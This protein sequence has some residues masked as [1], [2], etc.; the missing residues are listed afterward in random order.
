MPEEYYITS[1]YSKSDIIYIITLILLVGFMIAYPPINL[2]TSNT[3]DAICKEKYLGNESARSVISF[4]FIRKSDNKELTYHM[5]ESK[6]N[7]TAFNELNSE[8][9]KGNNCQIITDG[10][11]NVKEVKIPIDD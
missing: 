3:D 10:F 1:K 11:D 2:S 9:K 5:Y 4:R 8:I 7:K 6:Y